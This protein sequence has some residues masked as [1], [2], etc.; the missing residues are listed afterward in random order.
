M[1]VGEC[2]VS[3]KDKWMTRWLWYAS[4]QMPFTMKVATNN[5][6]PN[7]R[8][9]LAIFP[10]IEERVENTMQGGVFLL[11]KMKDFRFQISGKQ[12]HSHGFMMSKY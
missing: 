11:T 8:P 5:R 9:C 6:L 12:C 1:V 2:T 10:N 4:S 7:K 3:K